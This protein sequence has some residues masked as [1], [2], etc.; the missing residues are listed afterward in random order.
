MH[1]QQYRRLRRADASEYLL[2]RHGI[3][4]KPST[5]AKYASVGG[6]PKYLLA[7]RVPLYPVDELDAWAEAILSPL[8]ASTS[9]KGA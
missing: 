2:D 6:G 3:T 7:G 8:R 4:R 1:P 9:D 5:L